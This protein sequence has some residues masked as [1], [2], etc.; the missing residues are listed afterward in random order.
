MLFLI[1]L[2]NLKYF[3]RTDSIFP[4]IFIAP[5]G[6]V[7]IVLYYSIPDSFKIPG[8]SDGILLFVILVSSTMMMLA[9]MFSRD[10]NLL[11]EIRIH[12]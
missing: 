5:R 2:I 3:V 1:R 6:L 4:E 8:F 7:T 9:L 12:D 10:K 11:P